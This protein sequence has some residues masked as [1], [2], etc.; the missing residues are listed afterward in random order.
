MLEHLE[1]LVPLS[2]CQEACVHLPG[3]EYYVYDID[4]EDCELLAAPTRKCDILRGPPTPSY[5]DC[6][7]DGSTTNN[8]ITTSTSKTSKMTTTYKTTEKST[9]HVTTPTK[10]TTSNPTPSKYRLMIVGGVDDQGNR[11][12][13]VEMIDPAQADSNC[14]KPKS[15]PYN[16]IEMVSETFNGM[17]LVC[18][19][20]RDANQPTTE[21]YQYANNQWIGGPDRLALFRY[22]SSSV[23]LNDGRIWILGGDGKNGES[24]TSEILNEGG[25][26]EIGPALPEPMQSHCTA[27]IN[28]THVFFAGNGYDPQMQAYVVDISREPFRF[29]ELPSMKSKRFAAAC[30]V[31][32]DPTHPLDYRYTKLFVAGGDPPGYTSTEMFSFMDN[33]WTYGPQLERGFEFGGYINYPDTFN[34]FILIGGK[35]SS[36]SYHTDMMRYNYAKNSFEYLPGKITTARG[37][38]GVALHLSDDDC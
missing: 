37:D 32:V 1:R 24:I 5:E 34:E 25:Q 22:R 21:C 13:D 15:F 27:V 3:C 2:E 36:N 14:I 20:L 33:T 6:S 9:T 17:S 31:V 18:G 12:N 19:G 30:S 23:R 29:Y 35:D 7:R 38:F 11:L 8:P 10:Q 26:F 16:V 4:T 28:A